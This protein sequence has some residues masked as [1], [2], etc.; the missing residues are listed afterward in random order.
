MKVWTMIL[1]ALE[2]YGRCAMV[3][4]AE[5][6]GSAP[7]EAGARLIVTPGGFHGTIGGGALEWRALAAAQ[8]ALS[9]EG[10]SSTWSRMALGPELGQCC[11]GQMRLLMEVFD[12]SALPAVAAFAKRENG[13]LFMT[14][15]PIGNGPVLR[16]VI[17]APP[18]PLKIEIAGSMLLERFGND[19]RRLY[20]FGAGHVGRALVL[21]LAQLPFDV[22]WVD[23]RSDAFPAHTPRN[24]EVTEASD[25]ASALEE[26]PDGSFVLVMTHSHALDLDI[27]RAA[28]QENRFPHVGL[29]GSGTKRARFAKRLKE[30][31]IPA[32]RIVKLVCPIGVKG[33]RSKH[34]AAIAA[35]TAADLLIRD[36]KLRALA[37]AQ[38]KASVDASS[39][40]RPRAEASC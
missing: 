19:T 11:G 27:V 22:V 18:G 15:C 23:S 28:F 1:K 37:L 2:A 25:P 9:G 24:V 4:V 32:G 14:K 8:A 34:P 40:D 31:G 35:A 20:L 16:E 3:T 13:G 17:E 21:A 6:E 7:R 30:A 39:L 26:A 10:S 33:I 12:R 5:I 38:H 36:E 29:I